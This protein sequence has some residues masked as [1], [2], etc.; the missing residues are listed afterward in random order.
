M[1]LANDIKSILEKAVD[2]VGEDVTIT[3]LSRTTDN[4]G[5]ITAVSESDT[6]TIKVQF[7]NFTY[8]EKLLERQGQIE[9]GDAKIMIKTGASA[10]CGDMVERADGSR[11]E[12]LKK[13]SSKEV[14]GTATSES[15]GAKY[16]P[17]R[18]S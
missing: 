1:S 2:E 13:I 16:Y 3:R 11:Y 10:E 4:D 18:Q 9:L 8:T 15:W 6:E 5:K 14:M 7:A 17:A 12:L